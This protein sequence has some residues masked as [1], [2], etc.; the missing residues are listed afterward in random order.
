MVPVSPASAYASHRYDGHQPLAVHAA[1]RARARQTDGM[2]G[3]VVLSVD[4]ATGLS[5][6]DEV[7]VGMVITEARRDTRWTAMDAG[8]SQCSADHLQAH[9]R[10]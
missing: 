8:D 9:R 10:D 4:D 7:G 3:D 1:R 5:V 6:G 2:I